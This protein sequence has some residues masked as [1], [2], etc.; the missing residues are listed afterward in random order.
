MLFMAVC[1]G[2][3]RSHAIPLKGRG[4][5]CPT[6]HPEAARE[7]TKRKGLGKGQER[8]PGEAIEGKGTGGYNPPEPTP[9]RAPQSPVSSLALAL[10]AKM[11]RERAESKRQ[12][13]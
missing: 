13:I 4:F 2:C 12:R 8:F 10:L 6:C 11:R 7:G 9:P 5:P 3:G 1:L